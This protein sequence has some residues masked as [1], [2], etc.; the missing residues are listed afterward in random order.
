VF[1]D[2]ILLIKEAFMPA[3]E[4]YVDPSITAPV[5]QVGGNCYQRQGPSNM[6][7]NVT[8]PQGDYDDCSDCAGSPC[9]PTNLPD[10]YLSCDPYTGTITVCG[11]PGD[12]W[13]ITTSGSCTGI[14]FTPSSGTF[15]SGSG[16]KCQTITIKVEPSDT[17]QTCD[18]TFTSGTSTSQFVIY[19]M[20]DGCPGNVC[21][22]ID[23]EKNP[24]TAI[25]NIGEILG[26][27]CNCSF[28]YNCTTNLTCSDSGG[29][30]GDAPGCSM[31]APPNPCGSYEAQCSLAC[32]VASGTEGYYSGSTWISYGLIAGKLYWSLNTLIGGPNGFYAFKDFSRD[33]TGVY[34][35]PAA[36]G[37]CEIGLLS[38]SITIAT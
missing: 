3:D 32:Y 38:G 23:P 17:T 22:F 2:R 7:V 5:I 31:P 19:Q 13:S 15:P 9:T 25:Y 29:S 36:W 37:T 12:I 28:T 8:T 4:I 18:V 24:T 21:T 10:L 26:R 16:C 30:W 27:T 14:S 35:F 33:P 34:I 1:N 6:P 20:C 11:N